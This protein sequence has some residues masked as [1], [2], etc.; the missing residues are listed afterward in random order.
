MKHV[1]AAMLLMFS[2]V[3]WPLGGLFSVLF[4]KLLGGG[5]SESF[6]YTIYAG[7]ILLAGIAVACTVIILSEI[8]SLKEEL[9]KR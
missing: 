5:P 1:L 2:V 6:I 3:V 7:L 9:H 4:G 8:K